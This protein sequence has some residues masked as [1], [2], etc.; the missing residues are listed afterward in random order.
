MPSTACDQGRP[1][2]TVVNGIEVSPATP[3]RH[4]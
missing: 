3:R 2:V 1:G 4:S